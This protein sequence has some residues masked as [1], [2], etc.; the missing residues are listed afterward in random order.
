MTYRRISRRS[1]P[2]LLVGTTD[3]DTD[4]THEDQETLSPSATAFES[5]DHVVSNNRAAIR[6][7]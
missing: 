3:E 4:C 5:F 2:T 6:G 1:A 7:A